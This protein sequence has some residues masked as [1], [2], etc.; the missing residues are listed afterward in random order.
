[1]SQRLVAA[2]GGTPINFDLDEPQRNFLAGLRDFLDGTDLSRFIGANESVALENEADRSFF[3]HLNEAGW[4]GIAWP[5]EFGG[6]G[7]TATE[8]WLYL[9]EL[10]HRRLPRGDLTI[11]SIGPALMEFGTEQQKAAYL[12]GILSREVVFGVGYSEPDAGS[13][14][15]SLRTRAVL[16]G[17]EWVIDGQ[18]VFITSAHYSSHIWLAVRTDP[19]SVKREGISVVIVESDAPGL[20]ITNMATQADGITNELFFDSVRVPRSALVGEVNE[21]WRIIRAAL[22]YER[23]FPY[24]GLARDL[25]DL[26]EWAHARSVTTGAAPID[27][28]PTEA[29]LAVMA[30]DMEVARLFA[31]RVAA[32]IDS[33]EAPT[34]MASMSK[35]W[36]SELRERVASQGLQML[37]RDG[38]RHSEDSSLSIEQIYRWT[39]MMKIGGG[40]NEVQRDIISSQGL[41]LPRT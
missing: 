7:G 39:P 21:G 41:G 19:N 24:S 27:D 5:V 25:E 35:I 9:E 18:K 4:Q 8:Q 26:I 38:Q 10:S 17:D 29:T 12:P 30:A 33:G 1:M 31:A 14:L 15:A 13:D 34:A 16:D 20:T 11:S 36:T 40:T 2:P 28:P 22:D 32:A 23:N 6:K 3:E 37:G